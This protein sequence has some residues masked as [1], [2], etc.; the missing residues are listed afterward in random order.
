MFKLTQHYSGMV[1]DNRQMRVQ[2]VMPGM[3]I[4]FCPLRTRV[5]NTNKSLTLL[6]YMEKKYM[7]IEDV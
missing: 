4:P 2:E 1:A 7:L 6:L 5:H 3:Q